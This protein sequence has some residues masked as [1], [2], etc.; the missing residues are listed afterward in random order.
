MLGWLIA[1]RSEHGYFT[2]YNERFGHYKQNLHYQC[3]Q[4]GLIITFFVPKSQIIQKKT[5]LQKVGEAIST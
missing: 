1:A 3:R 4:T 2:N 5:I